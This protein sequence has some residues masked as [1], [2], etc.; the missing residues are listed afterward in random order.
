M[1]AHL[2]V[3]VETHNQELMTEYRK[4]TPGLVGQFGGRFTVRGGAT[5]TVEGDWQPQRIVF[6]EFPDMAALK[7]FY[8]APAYQPVL[9][10]RLDAGRSRAVAVE[11]E[12]CAPSHAFLMVDFAVTDPATL[13]TYFRQV[14]PLVSAQGGR[15]VVRSDKT[16]AIEA[17]WQPE[18]LTVVGFPDMAALRA[19]YFSDAYQALR[20]LRLSATRSRAILVEGV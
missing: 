18:R 1:P 12:A 13:A 4:H 15:L 14:Q 3:E 20:N 17:G 5:E 6:I 2:L 16:E 7:A 19:C 9:Q 10:M 8:A 11:G